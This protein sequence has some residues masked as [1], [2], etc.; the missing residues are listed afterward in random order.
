MPGIWNNVELGIR[1][2]I[3][4][5]PGALQRTD[6]V[7]TTVHDDPGDALQPVYVLQDL[8]RLEKRI[9]DKVVRL[10]ACQRQG[11]SRRTEKFHHVR[12]R[13]KGGCAAFPD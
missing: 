2:S 7:I 1:P 12:I 3:Y 6:H 8:F 5:L 9:V 11:R 4:Q 13:Q 10:N